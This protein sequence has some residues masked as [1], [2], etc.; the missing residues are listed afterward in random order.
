MAQLC[1]A[2]GAARV[3][4]STLASRVGTLTLI[5]V[6]PGSVRA[7]VPQQYT[8]RSLPTPQKCVGLPAS[9]ASFTPPL[10]GVGAVRAVEVPSPTLGCSPQHCTLA[11][12]MMA[13]VA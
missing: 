11:S 9:D 2:P 5:V 6:P 13:Q 1:C 8:D 10:V 4:C 7:L 3:H 12:G